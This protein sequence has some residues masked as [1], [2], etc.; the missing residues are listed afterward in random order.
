MNIKS[1]VAS[2]MRT[3]LRMIRDA[4]G[5][6]AVILSSRPVAGGIE[7]VSA[8]EYDQA[9][10]ARAMRA[11]GA[12]PADASPAALSALAQQQLP[13]GIPASVGIP[14][15]PAAAAQPLAAPQPPSAQ[16]DPAA[17][18]VAVMDKARPATHGADSLLARARAR[19]LGQPTEP[20][21]A[22]E[23]AQVHVAAPEAA[24]QVDVQ[25]FAAAL[26][27]RLAE[28]EAQA[29]VTLDMTRPAQP[30]T[31]APAA[32]AAAPI[33]EAPTEPVRPAL[34]LVPGIETDPAIVA[35]R[36][37]MARMRALME[38]QMEQ[39]S[40]ERL[41][42]SPARAAAFDALTGYGCEQALAQA[43][44]LRVDPSLPLAEV[45]AAMLAELADSLSIC[46]S[47]TIDE[48]GVIALVGPTGAGKTTTAAKL[49]ARF[50]ARHRARDVALI[51]TDC[52][53]PGAH[54]QLQAY[55]R[56]LGITVCE[57]RGI[58]GLQL[59]LEQLAD[60][61]L[62]L[63]D[64]TGY[65]PTDRALFNQILWLRATT[66][67]CSLLV[68]PANGH[69]QDMGEVIR[70]Y[71]PAAPEGLIL[72]KL[73]ETGYLGSALSV[74]ARTAMPIAYTTNGQRI[75]S[76]IDA[77]DALAIAQ[78]MESARRSS[79]VATHGIETRHA[80]A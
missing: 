66:K 49:A 37:E 6:D 14:A 78:A 27:A 58:G 22:A 5:P 73:D 63:V 25:D 79:D 57:A 13:A 19:L 35:M 39:L 62:V 42:G 68:L 67:V 31:P 65:A 16:P 24:A 52:E 10:L 40:L 47:E 15:Q 21:P 54:E 53:R 71:R 20:A 74:A 23:P 1:F 41:R 32:E 75:D 34:A 50:A 77:A 46:A 60:Y 45:S 69:A 70:R 33:I 36:E 29:T 4:Q 48:G 76:D 12:D 43:V 11:A 28:S 61:P 9:A 3:A 59:A 2:D 26:R 17:A 38:A 18:F 55:G 80:V 7:V 72:T 8:T 44:A 51:T 64:T 56:K 30:I